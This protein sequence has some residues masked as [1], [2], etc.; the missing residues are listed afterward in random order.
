M[1][2]APVNDAGG[3]RI[4][5]LIKLK[6]SRD[7]VWA[8]M[9]NVEQVVSCVPGASLLAENGD[10]LEIQMEASFGAISA[11]FKGEGRF[12][13]DD[14]SHSGRFEGQGKDS[15]SGSGASGAM[16]F[17]L[18]ADGDGCIL[19]LEASYAITGALSQFSRGGLVKSFASAVTRMF[20]DNL[21]ARLR[22]ETQNTSAAAKLSVFKLIAM[23][24]KG[25][26]RR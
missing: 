16:D 9:R 19:H 24:V 4:L 20:A 8:L 5:E 17:S 3:D 1:Q 18:E 23:V 7:D 15:R 12:T 25:W 10:Q 14:A 2:A 11:S 6:H 13:F 22:G 21:S 26:F